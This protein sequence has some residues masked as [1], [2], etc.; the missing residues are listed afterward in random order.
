MMVPEEEKQQS[1][2]EEADQ[3]FDAEDGCDPEPT[4]DIL[5][6]MQNL[7]DMLGE[8]RKPDLVSALL[9]PTNTKKSFEIKVQTDDDDEIFIVHEEDEEQ[10]NMFVSGEALNFSEAQPQMSNSVANPFKTNLFN[11]ELLPTTNKIDVFVNDNYMNDMK[12][13]K[14]SKSTHDDMIAKRR[15]NKGKKQNISIHQFDEETKKAFQDTLEKERLTI[16]EE[17]L[18]KSVQVIPT[19]S[20]LLKP[21]E[22]GFEIVENHFQKTTEEAKE[23]EEDNFNDRV[24]EA[25]LVAIPMCIDD[26]PAEIV[27][28]EAEEDEVD[29]I[30]RKSDGDNMEFQ[31]IAEINKSKDE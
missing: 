13:S 6:N 8:E 28:V 12:E 31:D 2:D 11:S 25:D 17:G 29:I 18:S 23:E 10:A 26:P 22:L 3:F 14:D 20:E 9:E 16:E 30:M 7:V 21:E 19:T 15:K 5:T 4:S 27:V 1:S 24:N